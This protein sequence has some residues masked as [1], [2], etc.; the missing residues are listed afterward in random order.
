M[1]RRASPFTRHQPTQLDKLVACKMFLYSCRKEALA[2]ISADQLV[3]RCG[4]TPKVA[5]YELT[6]ARQKRAAE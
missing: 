5:E 3:T 1:I 2:A 4:V 6:I